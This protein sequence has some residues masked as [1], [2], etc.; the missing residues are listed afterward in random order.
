[1]VPRVKKPARVQANESAGE[2]RALLALALS[3]ARLDVQ[4]PALR[5]REQGAVGLVERFALR[6]LEGPH[7]ADKRIRSSGGIR[8]V[9]DRETPKVPDCVRLCFGVGKRQGTK[10]AG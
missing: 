8:Q 2:S 9:K 7:L 5:R 3:P 6:G 10:Y 4:R 1:M